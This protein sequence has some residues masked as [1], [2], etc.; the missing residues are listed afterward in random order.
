MNGSREQEN[1]RAALDVKLGRIFNHNRMVG[2]QYCRVRRG[3]VKLS[4]ARY[5][6]VNQG[7]NENEKNNSTD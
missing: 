2:V 1:L 5:S 7:R 4:K 6:K 3:M